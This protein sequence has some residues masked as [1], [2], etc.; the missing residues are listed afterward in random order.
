MQV[1]NKESQQLVL[2]RPKL[3]NGFQGKAFKDRVRE[4]V[5]GCVISSWT[6]FAL[7]AC[8]VIGSQHHQPSGSSWSGVYMLAGN[9][10]LTS[11][12]SGGFSIC[13][14]AQKIWL[15]ILSIALEAEL[16]VLDFV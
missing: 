6:F 9:I 8:E 4:R 5:A 3:L 14:T 11:S 16:K 10:Q 13:K 2:K 12:T 1:P 15:R 7:V